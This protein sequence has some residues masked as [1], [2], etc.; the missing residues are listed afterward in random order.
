MADDP[1]VDPLFDCVTC[2]ACCAYDRSWPVVEAVDRGP[3]GPPAAL[4]ERGAMKWRKGR[5]VALEGEL[6]ERV[7]C[8]IYERRPSVCRA[9]EPGSVSCRIARRERGFPV[10]EELS[11]MD[12]LVG[13]SSGPP[14]R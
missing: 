1:V 7:R 2:G 3:H 11:T 4:V 13:W 9:C 5:C 12:L 6:G 14:K 8:T 10:P